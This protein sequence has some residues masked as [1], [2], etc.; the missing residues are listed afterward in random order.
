M[1]TR[2]ITT[3][4]ILFTQSLLHAQGGP[5]TPPGPPAPTMKSLDQ[6]EPRIA[7]QSLAAAPPYILSTPGSYYLTGNISV[8]T[9]NAIS[10]TV[11]GVTLDLNGF[12]V[13]ST[14]NPASGHAVQLGSGIHNIAVSNGH[15]RSG[16][17]LS[18][19]IFTPL[20]FSGGIGSFASNNTSVEIHRLTISGIA[21]G[22][23]ILG[24]SGSNGV[25]CCTVDTTSA[26]GIY[27][28]R[29]SHCS[30]QNCGSEGIWATVVSD[31]AAHTQNLSAIYAQTVT[32]S[33]AYSDTGTGITATNVTNC[34]GTSNTGPAGIS[35]S[36]AV[37]F[38]QGT[39]SGG[40]AIT[41]PIAIGCTSGG[42]TIISAQKHLGTP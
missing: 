11:S 24:G 25:S 34:I 16:T 28:G 30:V 32:N 21:G 26:I 14:A 4:A 18:G 29:A 40:T 7:V 22:G 17:T 2:I 5:L 23:I 27:A 31:C 3:L 41:A 9:G 38:S 19:G 20:G 36:G 42:G 37:S 10:I 35:A 6:I 39:R 33:Q 12:S 13:S 15:I 8:T 1:K